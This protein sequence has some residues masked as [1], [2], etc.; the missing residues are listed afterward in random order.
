MLRTSN[1]DKK[2]EQLEV[3]E[4]FNERYSEENTLDRE[5]RTQEGVIQILSVALRVKF[6]R[7]TSN[8]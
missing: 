1:T 8:V 7:S 4:R 3:I 6:L 5:A 2:K